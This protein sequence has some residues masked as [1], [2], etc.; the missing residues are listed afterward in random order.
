MCH[1]TKDL[2]RATGT[3]VLIM[4]TVFTLFSRSLHTTRGFLFII[5]S[6]LT[7][8]T[9][10]SQGNAYINLQIKALQIFEN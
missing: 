10:T 2:Q 1:C 9:L 3:L 8:F 4:K 5:L 6:T 7:M